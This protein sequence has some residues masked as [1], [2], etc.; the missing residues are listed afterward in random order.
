MA[1]KSNRRVAQACGL[2]LIGLATSAVA[3]SQACFGPGGCQSPSEPIPG[4]TELCLSAELGCV[5]VTYLRVDVPG[6]WFSVA[7]ATVSGYPTLGW[8]GPCFA[9][10]ECPAIETQAFT[11]LTTQAT[12]ATR[13]LRFSPP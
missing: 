13:V 4:P 10:A 12:R 7:T 9:G 6:A 8:S 5:P 1:I 2:A 11:D 3:F